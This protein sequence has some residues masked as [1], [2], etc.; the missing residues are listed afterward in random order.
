MTP[1]PTGRN[2][3]VRGTTPC[4]RL[5]TATVEIAA[6]PPDHDDIRLVNVDYREPPTSGCDNLGAS[7]SRSPAGLGRRSNVPAYLGPVMPRSNDAVVSLSPLAPSFAEE[8][9]RRSAAAERWMITQPED[10]FCR[11]FPASR[12]SR[13]RPQH[14]AERRCPRAS[15]PSRWARRYSLRWSTRPAFIAI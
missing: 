5:N 14:S 12:L 4:V 3:G 6:T 13:R 9:A 10:R 11:N 1:F 2:R 15:I 7:L 8:P